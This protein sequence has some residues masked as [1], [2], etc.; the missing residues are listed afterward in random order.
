[1][2][3]S[4]CPVNDG[5]DIN[6]SLQDPVVIKE[7]E[8][9]VLEVTNGTYPQHPL[10]LLIDHYSS[11]YRLCNAVSWLLRFKMFLKEKTL[12]KGFVRHDEMVNAERHVVSFVQEGSFPVEIQL[13]NN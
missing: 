3:K 12:I 9:H 2:Y 10:N 1:M 8:A 5:N 7:K 11:F 6:I 13:K 4:D